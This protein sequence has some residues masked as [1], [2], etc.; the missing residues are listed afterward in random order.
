MIPQPLRIDI[1]IENVLS[2]VGI[3]VR[4]A[5]EYTGGVMVMF[6][7]SM[8]ASVRRPF[9]WRS[10]VEQIEIIGLQSMPIVVLTAAFTG[11]VMALQYAHGMAR[12]GAQMY[13]GK[14]VA[15]TLTRELGPVLTSLMVGGRVGAGIAAEIGSM[16]VTEQIDAV[17]ALGADP[18]KKLVVPRVL[19]AMFIMPFLSVCTDVIGLFGG[20]AVSFLEYDIPMGFFAKS[21]IEITKFSDFFSGVSKTL[22][23][24]IIIAVVGCYQGFRTRGGTEG[25]GRATTEAVVI[26]SVGILI[27][28]YILTKLFLS[29]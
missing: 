11:M 9:E 29:F 26:I 3:T 22:F 17:R 19:A 8:R 13:T 15:L 25:V 6:F 12:F 23:F 10:V 14:L 18:V 21:A 5:V 4:G 2:R 24:G 28:D 1:A 7:R 16:A 20:M 27:A